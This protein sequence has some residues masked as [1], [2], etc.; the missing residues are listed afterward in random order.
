MDLEL[1]A[2][3]NLMDDLQDKLK[4][5]LITPETMDSLSR[6]LIHQCAI[7]GNLEMLKYLTNLWGP[8]YLF[9]IDKYGMTL[10]HFAARNGSL[11]ILNYLKEHGALTCS[12]DS[13]FSTT[14]LALAIAMKHLHCLDLLI[15]HSNQE[16]LNSA[17]LS[18]SQRGN[19]GVVKKLIENH[20]DIEAVTPDTKA[21]SLDRES[22]P[23]FFFFANEFIPAFFET[24]I[25]IQ[26]T[27]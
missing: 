15:A 6:N 3:F 4:K 14:P 11:D 25:L 2:Q 26:W 18:T 22:N 7:F 17:L 1:I 20:A 21:T 19:L 23:L 12:P 24:R 13:R 10:S 5:Q 16:A 8:Q 27:Y 9:L